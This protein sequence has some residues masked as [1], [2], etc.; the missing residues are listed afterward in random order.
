M[1]LLFQLIQ[2]EGGEDRE[3]EFGLWKH[4]EGREVMAKVEKAILCPCFIL[5][6]S[7][8]CRISHGGLDHGTYEVWGIP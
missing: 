4:L 7:P 1:N 8:I 3:D 2:G 6:L 5:A